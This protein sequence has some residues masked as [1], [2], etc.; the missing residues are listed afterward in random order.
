MVEKKAYYGAITKSTSEDET[1]FSDKT[2]LS[3]FFLMSMR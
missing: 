2:F 1:T 3:A